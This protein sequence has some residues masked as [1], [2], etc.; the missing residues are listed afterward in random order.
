MKLLIKGIGL[1]QLP[2]YYVDSYLKSGELVKV[3]QQ[4]QIPEERIWAVYPHNRH[5]SAKVRLLVD[6]LHAHL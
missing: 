4:F 6:Y 2:N 1:V 5:L 3:L